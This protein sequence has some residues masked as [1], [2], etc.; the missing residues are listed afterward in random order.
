MEKLLKRLRAVNYSVV[1]R[2]TL[3]TRAWISAIA[4]GK[5][6]PSEE[7]KAK[8]IKALDK[9]EADNAAKAEADMEFARQAIRLAVKNHQ[10][11]IA[12]LE[13]QLAGLDGEWRENISKR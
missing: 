10:D 2:E 13:N 9:V 8:I 7:G 5:Q 12:E 3:Y 6:E 4:L 11:Q 1:A